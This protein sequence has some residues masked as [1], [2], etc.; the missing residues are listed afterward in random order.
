MNSHEGA[1]HS[2]RAR[3]VPPLVTAFTVLLVLLGAFLA[4]TA[5]AFA[6][7]ASTGELAFYPCDR[8]HPVVLGPDGKPTKPLP[9]GLEKHEICLLYTSDAADDLLCVDLG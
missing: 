9:I 2:R 1:D 3:R 7:Q 8:C 5:S 4:L 6:G